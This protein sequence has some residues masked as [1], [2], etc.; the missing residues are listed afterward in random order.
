M[1]LPYLTQR[2]TELFKYNASPYKGRG[3]ACE[4]EGLFLLVQHLLQRMPAEHRAFHAGGHMAHVLQHTGLLQ[5]VDLLLASV[6]LN[7]A[8]KNITEAQ[9]LLLGLADNQIQHHVGAG[10]ANGAAAAGEGAI[11]NNAL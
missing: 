8:Q 4:T 6:A 7:H 1:C 10:L 9:S 5:L 2:G 11:H 3:R